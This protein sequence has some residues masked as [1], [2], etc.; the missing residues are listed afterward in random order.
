MALA[1]RPLGRGGPQVTAVGLGLMGLSA[2]YGKPMSNEERWDF[3][4]Y[5]HKA[6]EHFWDSADVYGDNEDLIGEWFRRT[7][8]RDDIF[9]ATKFGG[10]R[11]IFFIRL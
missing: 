1:T 6:G 9:L 5:A 2:F 10:T 3:L 4:S 8:N 11:K 7:G